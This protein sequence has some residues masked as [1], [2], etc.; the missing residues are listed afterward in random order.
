[1]NNIKL[2]ILEYVS[3]HDWL[4]RGGLLDAMGGRART[5][6]D[7]RYLVDKGYL[8]D[9][10]SVELTEKGFAC[11]DSGSFRNRTI[12]IVKGVLGIVVSVLIVVAG[13]WLW[14]LIQPFL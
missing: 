3:T 12:Q 2:K 8:L 13:N 11:I 6:Q 14:E 5:E 9:S 1:M 10:G 7:I 4:T